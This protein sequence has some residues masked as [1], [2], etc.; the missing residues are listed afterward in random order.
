[1]PRLLE[2]ARGWIATANQAH[3]AGDGFAGAQSQWFGAFRIEELLKST[4]RAD[5]E[6][7]K[8]IQCDVQAVDARFLLPRLL[9]LLEKEKPVR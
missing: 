7:M 3:S 6:S 8:R 9:E 1:M 2:P 4:K 5:F